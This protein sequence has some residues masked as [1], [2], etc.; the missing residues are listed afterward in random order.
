MSSPSA[1]PGRRPWRGVGLA[2]PGRDPR[3][4]RRRCSGCSS[5]GASSRQ[6]PGECATAAR[7][8][9]P[10]RPRLVRQRRVLRR[11]RL[12]PAARA[13]RR[14]ATRSR[15][16]STTAR[17]STCAARASWRSRSRAAR[18]TSSST[19]EGPPAGRV[20]RGAHERPA[21]GARR[22]LRAR[23]CRSA[24]GPSTRSPPRRPT[25]RRWRRW[26]FSPAAP[27]ARGP[28]SRTVSAGPPSSSRSRC[29]TSRPAS[30]S[31]PSRS[32]SSAECS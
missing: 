5:T 24:P 10:G 11:L 17:S 14:C 13:G 7:A 9:S 4:A 27:P 26:R 12:R 28:S 1:S 22:G 30:R 23:P 15:S 3:A 31:R 2:A 19:R 18:P 32:R 6:W 16:P 21:L 29:P 8:R 25:R 20:H